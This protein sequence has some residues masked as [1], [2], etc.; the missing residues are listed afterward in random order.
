MNERRRFMKLGGRQ[1]G[2]RDTSGR[3]RVELFPGGK[4]V[5]PAIVLRALRKG[6]R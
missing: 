4:A 6:T 2:I 5:H 1:C 3:Q